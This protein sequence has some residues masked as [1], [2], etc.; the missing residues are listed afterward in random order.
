MTDQKIRQHL[1]CCCIQSFPYLRLLDDII[2]HFFGPVDHAI[3]K[4]SLI[5][6]GKHLECEHVLTNICSCFILQQKPRKKELLDFLTNFVGQPETCQIIAKYFKPILAELVGRT[7]ESIG[8]AV[9]RGDKKHLKIAYSI[10]T[11]LHDYPYLI[12]ITEG[13]FGCLQGTLEG[14]IEVEILVKIFV[15][16]LE[17]DVSR[18]LMFVNWDLVIVAFQN[19][20]L[21]LKYSAM[22]CLTLAAGFVDLS[23]L[24][25]EETLRELIAKRTSSDTSKHRELSKQNGDENLMDS[26]Q[27]SDIPKVEF[28]SEDIRTNL[29]PVAGILMPVKNNVLESS[30][31]NS[32]LVMTENT[33][34]TLQSLVLSVTTGTPVLLEGELGTGKTVI[35]EYFASMMGRFEAPEILKL[36]LGDQTDSKVHLFLFTVDILVDTFDILF[37]ETD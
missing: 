34:K 26:L 28:T 18:F 29:V 17:F 19:P 20:D 2:L 27:N 36:Q 35:L 32:G 16:L 37:T 21:T 15:N 31:W 7:I 22:R 3:I 30:L 13:L 24:L 6:F 10:S 33:C 23:S 14:Q 1:L 4:R 5:L 25:P 9:K 12:D 11:L 8:I